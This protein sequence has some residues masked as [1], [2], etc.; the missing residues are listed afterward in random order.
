MNLEYFQPK[1]VKTATKPQSLTKIQVAGN[2][3]LIF[4]TIQELA[5]WIARA[6]S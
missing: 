2:G 6:T 5:F 3:F 1:I 4:G